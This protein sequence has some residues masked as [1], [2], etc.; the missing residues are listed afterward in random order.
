M[1]VHTLGICL[2]IS[3]VVFGTIYTVGQQVL[4]QSANDPQ[5][6]LAE[7]IAQLLSGSTKP[8]DLAS[9]TKV[10]IAASLA[11]FLVITDAK[12]EVLIT[13][14][15]LNGKDPAIPLGV[16]DST[17]K[18]G[19][20]R[21]TWQPRKDVRIALVV[22]PYKDGYVAVGRSLR[23]VEKREDGILKMVGAAWG[24]LVILSC[25]GYLGMMRM[26]LKK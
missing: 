1:K 16:F 9:N 2:V 11:P 14:G 10:D 24:G 4:R 5:I 19:Q 18:M 8:S 17:K 25:M 23:E 22:V 26:R 15:Q 6:Q 20:D 7:D 3:V 12:G 13:S 21:I